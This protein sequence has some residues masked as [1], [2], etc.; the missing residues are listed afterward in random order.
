M[1]IFFLFLSAIDAAHALCDKHVVSQAKET[2]QMLCSAWRKLYGQKLKGELNTL[3]PKKKRRKTAQLTQEE[4]DQ[5]VKNSEKAQTKA[6]KLNLYKLTHGNHPMTV[7]VSTSMANF[8]WALLHGIALCEEWKLRYNH[9]EE[10]EHGCMR[11]FKFMLKNKD[12]LSDLFPENSFTMPPQCMP[13]EYRTENDV[14]SAYRAYYK[15]EKMHFAKWS[16][17]EKPDFL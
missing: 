6:D 13:E 5:I 15:G 11:I 1:N 14:V 4:W 3:K 16:N 7:W 8:E 2:A 9:P 17:R 12:Q 10:K